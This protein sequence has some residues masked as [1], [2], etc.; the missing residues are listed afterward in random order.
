[1]G[2][3]SKDDPRLV[4]VDEIH[5]YRNG[6]ESTVNTRGTG[7]RNPDGSDSPGGPSGGGLDSWSAQVVDSDQEWGTVGATWLVDDHPAANEALAD[8][9]DSWGV[10]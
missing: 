6:P 9:F 10:S 2:W 7:R 4:R 3:F 1:M 8:G 5:H